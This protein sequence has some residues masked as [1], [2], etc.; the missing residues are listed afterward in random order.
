MSACERLVKGFQAPRGPQTATPPA[1]EQG[2]VGN[3]QPL[4][5]LLLAKQ[6]LS[7]FLC[8]A[9]LSMQVHSMA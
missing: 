2:F 3:G 7:S 1:E 4:L 8:G 9:G 6:L 5:L